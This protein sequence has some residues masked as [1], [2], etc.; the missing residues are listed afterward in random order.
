MCVCVCCVCVWGGGGGGAG[1]EGD[2]CGGRSEGVGGGVG[3]VHIAT[4]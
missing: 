1:T 4:L 2:V 3:V